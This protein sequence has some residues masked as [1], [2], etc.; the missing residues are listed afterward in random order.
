MR[1][2][3]G[4]LSGIENCTEEGNL[5]TASYRLAVVVWV[6]IA[7]MLLS[8]AAQAQAPVA[9]PL[10]TGLLGR[11]SIPSQTYF[12]G[13]EELYRGEY[14][15]AERAFRYELGGSVKIGV[16]ARWIDA[17]CYHAMLGETYYQQGR[18]AEALDQ[19][20]LACDMFLQ[21]PKWMLQVK[22]SPP[23][24]DTNLLRRGI[25]WGAS[26]R[27][28]TLG[29]FSDQ[30]QI[31]LGD[32][33]SAN[34]AVQQGGVVRQAQYWRV[35]VVE[36]LRTTALAIR[37]RN[38][39]LG[40]LALDDRM[41]RELGSALAGGVAPPNHWSKAWVEL[42]KGLAYVGQGKTDLALK[43]LQRAERVAGQFDH[44]LTCVALLEQGRLAMEAGDSTNADRLLA[45]AGFSA[46]YYEDPG[47][48]DEAFRLASVNRLASQ[49]LDSSAALEPAAIWARRERYSHIFV[50]LNLA[51][52]EELMR[53]GRWENAA[54]AVKAAQSQLEDAVTGRLGAWSRYLT[55]RVMFQQGRSKASNMLAQAVE[56][57][58]GMSTR[59]F[60]IELANRRYDSRQLTPRTAVNVYLSLLDDPEMKDWVFRP[61]ETLAV[62]RTPHGD[63]FDRW[64]DAL[65]AQKNVP[66]ALEAT[67][68]AKRR[69]FHAVSPWGSRLSSLRDTMEAPEERL[70]PSART[71]RGELNL[72]LPEYQ[73]AAQLGKQLQAD[74]KEKWVE[75]LEPDAE[76]ELVKLWRDWGDTLDRREAMLTNLALDRV[77]AEMGF[78]PL[79][80]VKEVQSRLRPGQAVLVFHDTG[81]GLLGFL[82]TSTASTNWNCGPSGRLN[83]AVADFL[84]DIGNYD[85]NHDLEAEELLSSAWLASGQKLFQMLFQGSSIDPES[86]DELVIVPDGVV[87][88][89]P[90]TALPV[91]TEEK[92]VP[93]IAAARVRVAPTLGLAVGSA[94][95]WRR[96]QHAAIVGSQIVPGDDEQAQIEK[97]QSF[98][99]AVVRPTELPD[100]LPI[101]PPQFGSL[102]DTLVVL[103]E[104]TIEQ[105]SPF[106]WSP[107]PAGRSAAQSS[108]EEWFRLPQFGPQRMIFP[109]VHTIAENGGKGAKRRGAPGAELFLST[110]G[111]MSTGAQTILL[112]RWRVGG[113]ST[114]EIVREFVQELPHTDASDAWQRSVQLAKELTIHPAVEPRVK[115]GKDDTPLTASHPFFW[116][117]YLLVDT[118]A[119]I[120]EEPGGTDLDTTLGDNR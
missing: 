119:T 5:V 95:T 48:I 74:L 56:Q 26:G 81:A 15:D 110:C 70:S 29:N 35:N 100:P 10:G 91:A 38:E 87:W 52:A 53:A 77:P 64:I 36:I 75:G 33:Y 106:G 88:Y 54:G 44:P 18:P 4:R 104:Q 69:H 90:M 3:S 83:R 63:A 43:S 113:E 99:T 105:S 117:G 7:A 101:S 8:A 116:S 9:G 51:W 41:S 66:R 23:R 2:S 21:N 71:I 118:G 22:F 68:R 107:L 27:Q 47:T 111:L 25:P 109:A 62:L 93:L 40:P 114:M 57:Q 78:P 28:F 65:F 60:Q 86:L 37:R 14:R 30:M 39:L 31:L 61:L 89:V 96:M 11:D 85:A 73:Q 19:F 12:A 72:R 13:I 20:S 108:L 102:L 76:R 49:P 97:L 94:A 92:V 55:A 82:M 98:R 17:I 84:R 58:A 50:R 80:T 79:R 120:G 115:A 45:E 1:E 67:D 34:R 42:L 24:P 59:N 6:A 46:F 32:L 16:T 103:D 112:S